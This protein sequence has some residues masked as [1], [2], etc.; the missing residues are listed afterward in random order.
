MMTNGIANQL[1]YPNAYSFFYHLLV[2]HLFQNLEDEGAIEILIRVL[3]ERL[4]VSR[5]HPWFLL[6]TI[7]RVI[8]SPAWNKWSPSLY[9]RCSE[10]RPIMQRVRIQASS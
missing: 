9:S 5:P 4:L 3:V 10:L 1:R 2:M 7:A 6:A 8:Q